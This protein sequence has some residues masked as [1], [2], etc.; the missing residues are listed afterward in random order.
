MDKALLI[1]TIL[2]TIGAFTALCWYAL[3][4]ETIIEFD[5]DCMH[6]KLDKDNKENI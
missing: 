5:D 1:V 6:N 4:A 3:K 2:V